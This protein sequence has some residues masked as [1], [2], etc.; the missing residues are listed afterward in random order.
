MDDATFKREHDVMKLFIDNAKNYV[1]LS[2]AALVLSVSF[3]K[4]ILGNEKLVPDAW[5]I[6]AWVTFSFAI[7][8]G[9]FYQY[10]AAKYLERYLK[11]HTFMTWDWLAESPGSIYGI[12]LLTFYSGVICFTVCAIL[13]LHHTH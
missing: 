13:R 7:I 6:A 11:S 2:G 8:S 3:L 5:L 12:M 1:Q 9:A 4:D 10:L